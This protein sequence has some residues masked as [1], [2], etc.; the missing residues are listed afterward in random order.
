MDALTD[1]KWAAVQQR[2]A[3]ERALEVLCLKRG[4]DPTD[5]QAGLF[6]IAFALY[7]VRGMIEWAADG[8]H[9][10]ADRQEGG[11]ATDE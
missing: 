2:E 9:N 5:P 11:E 1:E 6:A 8:I 4:L 3:D 7:R 10:I